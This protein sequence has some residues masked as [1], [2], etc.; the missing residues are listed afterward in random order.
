MAFQTPGDM[1][2]IDAAGDLSGAQFRFLS[3]DSAGRAVQA[4]AGVAV[5]GVA[6]DNNADEIDKAV[7]YMADGLSKVEAG[8]AV[9]AGV[10][11]AS[12]AS[13][14]AIAAVS[15]NRVAG[16]ARLAAAGAGTI[17]TVELLRG[18]QL[19]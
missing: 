17:I 12:D 14:R 1:H 5:I 6:Q 13:G 4:G 7:A 16:I 3:V 9:T 11:V 2:S 10:E 18:G 19:N 15:G 8:A